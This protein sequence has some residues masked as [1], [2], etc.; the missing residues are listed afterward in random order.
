V[1]VAS[2]R[3]KSSKPRF[4]QFLVLLT[5]ETANNFLNENS[6]EAFKAYKHLPEQA[7]AILFKDIS[8]KVYG[9]FSF[10]ELFPE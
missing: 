6:H 10:K 8:N 9:R 1:H 5:G 3:Y 7:F 2:S 4:T